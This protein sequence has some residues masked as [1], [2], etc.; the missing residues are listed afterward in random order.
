[1]TKYLG[2]ETMVTMYEELVKV[3]KVKCSLCL[4]NEALHHEGVRGSVCIDPHFS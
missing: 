4:I 1:M 2:S 3:R